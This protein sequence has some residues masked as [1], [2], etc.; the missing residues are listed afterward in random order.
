MTDKP[1]ELGFRA[2]PFTVPPESG[3]GMT[4]AVEGPY[5]LGADGHP[6]WILTTARCFGCCGDYLNAVRAKKLRPELN[7]VIAVR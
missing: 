6:D 3:T 7:Y 4:S 2:P 5:D 1:A